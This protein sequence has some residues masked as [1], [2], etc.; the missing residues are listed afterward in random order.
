MRRAKLLPHF[1]IRVFMLRLGVYK[2]Y[3][4]ADGSEAIR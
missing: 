1:R 4:I 2:D 3:T